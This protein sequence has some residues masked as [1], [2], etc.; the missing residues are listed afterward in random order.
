MQPPTHTHIYSLLLASSSIYSSTYSHSLIPSPNITTHSPTRT[1]VLTQT[2]TISHPHSPTFTCIHPHN[3]NL[4]TLT[5]LH[6]Y[7]LTHTCTQTSPTNTCTLKQALT[8]THTLKPLVDALTQTHLLTHPLTYAHSLKQVHTHPLHLHTLIHKLKLTHTHP[9]ANVHIQ[10]LIYALTYKYLL[11]HSLTQS[12]SLSL[13]SW[14][15][16]WCLLQCVLVLGMW[17]LWQM[18]PLRT[19][20]NNLSSAYPRDVQVILERCPAFVQGWPGERTSAVFA[21]LRSYGVD[22]MFG[23]PQN[24]PMTLRTAPACVTLPQFVMAM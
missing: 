13:S 7:I 18:C 1:C 15:F 24:V 16:P 20:T 8:N 22:G 17:G 23:K 6:T 12:F 11:S 5:H 2:Y 19:A 10:P 3:P 9:P 4:H 14:V 21:K